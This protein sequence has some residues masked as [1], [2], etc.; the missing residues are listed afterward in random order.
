[1]YQRSREALKLVHELVD[2]FPD[3]EKFD[4]ADQMRRASKSVPANITEGYALRQS[5]KEFRRYL[6]AAMASANEMEAHVEIARD[7]NYIANDAA[8]RLIEEYQ[9]IGKQLHRL[10]ENWRSFE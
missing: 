1:M 7:L 2:A 5:V 3:Y 4:L 10:I 9:I 8:A 6:R